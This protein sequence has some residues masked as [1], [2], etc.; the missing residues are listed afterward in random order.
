MKRLGDRGN[1]GPSAP[2]S[3]AAGSSARRKRLAC[4]PGL[5]LQQPWM[6]SRVHRSWSSF[7]LGAGASTVVTGACSYGSMRGKMPLGPSILRPP[8]THAFRRECIRLLGASEGKAPAT[9]MVDRSPVQVR[10]G[11]RPR[12]S[13][14]NRRG[15]KFHAAFSGVRQHRVQVRQP[16]RPVQIGIAVQG[17]HDRHWWVAGCRPTQADGTVALVLWIT[18]VWKR[19]A[20]LL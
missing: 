11:P 2:G 16:H 17:G 15:I 7:V 20:P 8:S 5:K 12:R 4:R 10:P 1:R 9:T 19:L 6:V 3:N 18:P 14:R 13:S